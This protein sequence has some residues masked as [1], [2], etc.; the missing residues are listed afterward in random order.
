MDTRTILLCCSVPTSV[1]DSVLLENFVVAFSEN[2]SSGKF[3]DLSMIDIL[4]IGILFRVVSVPVLNFCLMLQKAETVFLE[5]VFFAKTFRFKELPSV[6]NSDFI[7][8]VPL[9]IPVFI[10][11][12]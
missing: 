2:L 11:C 4:Y 8:G 12:N 10:R 3:F 9:E 6:M 1:N 5:K 7:L